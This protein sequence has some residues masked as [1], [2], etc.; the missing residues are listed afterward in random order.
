MTFDFLQTN[1]ISFKVATI[2]RIN[3]NNEEKSLRLLEQSRKVMTVYCPEDMD[4]LELCNQI[5]QLTKSY[6]GWYDIRTPSSYEHY[7]G[8]LFYRCDR[9]ENGYYIFPQIKTAS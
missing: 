8:G 5:Y 7:A 3:C 6:K 1:N 9:D 2:N 4:H